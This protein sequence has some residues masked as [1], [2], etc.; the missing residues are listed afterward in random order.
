MKNFNRLPSIL[1]FLFK[2]SNTFN[3][4]FFFYNILLKIILPKFFIHDEKIYIYKI[5]LKEKK[6]NDQC[7]LLFEQINQ[8]N[9]QKWKIKDTCIE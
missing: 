7:D 9:S 3:F 4:L 5:I 6:R 2:Y 8:N 1:F